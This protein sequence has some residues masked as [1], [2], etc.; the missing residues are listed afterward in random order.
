MTSVKDEW[1][2]RLDAKHEA[3]AEELLDA[4]KVRVGCSDCGYRLHP[5]ALDL[6]RTRT[7]R[8]AVRPKNALQA[9]AEMNLCA[10]RCANCQAIKLVG[11]KRQAP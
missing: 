6:Y 5:E 3:S 1:F 9:V 8:R 11:R 10:V 4:H 2:R 7:G